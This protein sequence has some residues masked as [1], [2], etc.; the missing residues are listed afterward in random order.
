MS[1]GFHIRRALAVFWKDFL[2]LRKNRALLWSLLALPAVLVVVPGAVVYSYL[3]SPDDPNLRVIAMYY[4]PQ[5]P[6]DVDA[7]RFLV[8]RSLT[9]WF[10]LFLMMP[11]FVPILISSQAI[12]GE[13]ERRTLEP[14]LASPVTAAE[15]VVGKSL[16]SLVPAVGI[17]FV[18]F[19]VFCCVVDAVAWPYVHELILPN[20]MWLFG[21]FVIAPLFAFFGN[22]VAVVISARVAEARL[23]QQL[24]GLFV[25]PLVGLVGGQVAGFLRAGPAYYAIQGAV[26]LVLDVVLVWVAVKLFDRERL[27]SRWS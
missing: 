1:E 23:A 25:L 19:A 4:E 17:C 13:K 10:G 18:A 8:D 7:A 22:G 2:D 26:V 15:L 16:A 6:L 11:V 9:D 12:A 5:L 27:I 21:V 24:S 3:H 20:G 14:L